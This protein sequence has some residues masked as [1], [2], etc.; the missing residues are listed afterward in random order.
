MSSNVNTREKVFDMP[1]NWVCPPLFWWIIVQFTWF[2]RLANFQS[3]RPTQKRV[4]TGQTKS[5]KKVCRVKNSFTCFQKCLVV[6][7]HGFP[8]SSI[9]YS[10]EISMW[11]LKL[12]KHSFLPILPK[13]KQLF[14]RIILVDFIGLG[15]SDKPCQSA[16]TYS[17]FEQT[18]M[19]EALLN[20]LNLTKSNQPSLHIT[21]EHQLHKK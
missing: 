7:L 5:K 13:L 19:V 8:T 14:G 10:K 20:Y 17:I 4:A 3:W 1:Y 18:D 6:L 15:F 11:F 12:Q 2:N 21:M 16:Y 9:E